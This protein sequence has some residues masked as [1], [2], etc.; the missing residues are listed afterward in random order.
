MKT[1]IAMISVF[2]EIIFTDFMV[3]IGNNGYNILAVCVD[4]QS[5]HSQLS[6]KH[7]ASSSLVKVQANIYSTVQSTLISSIVS[8][9]IVY[10]NLYFI[11]CVSKKFVWN[12]SRRATAGNMVTNNCRP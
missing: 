4:S 11:H 5:V 2:N 8:Y 12:A 6:L 3:Y 10:V 1:Q 9:R 7:A